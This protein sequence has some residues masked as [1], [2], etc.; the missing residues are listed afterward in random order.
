MTFICL[1]LSL[2]PLHVVGVCSDLRYCVGFCAGEQFLRTWNLGSKIND[3][4][5]T[6]NVHKAH[7]DGTAE[8]VTMQ[9]YPR[10]KVHWT[11]RVHMATVHNCKKQWACR[12]HLSGS[13]ICSHFSVHH[14]TMIASVVLHYTNLKFR[15]KY[16]WVIPKCH[17][18]NQ[19]E[20][21]LYMYFFFGV[22]FY[23]FP[24]IQVCGL[25]KHSTR[26]CEI[27]ERGADSIQGS[28]CAS[29]ARSVLKFRHRSGARLETLY[30]VWPRH[31]QLHRCIYICLPGIS[32]HYTGWRSEN[33][34]WLYSCL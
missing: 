34:S 15:P 7:S 26:Y 13:A 12:R 4:T 21:S 28:S 17:E 1:Y 10:Y 19:I 5:L 33:W 6:Y 2:F 20:L 14:V 22:K 29:G 3:Q 31:H 24:L 11:A 16:I 8:I 32:V 18:S 25:S 27:M 9:R 23:N 30:T